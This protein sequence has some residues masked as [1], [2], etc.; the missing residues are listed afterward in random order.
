MDD[1]TAGTEGL[2]RRERQRRQDRQDILDAA[3]ALFAEQG[4]TA[5]SMQAIAERAEFSVGKLYTFFEGKQEIFDQLIRQFLEGMLA[6]IEGAGDPAAEPI[7]NLRRLFEAS[8]AFATENRDLIRVSILERHRDKSERHEDLH[9]AFRRNVT[10]CLESAVAEGILPPLRTELYGRM[11]LG[12]TDEMVM[13]LGARDVPDP[14]AEATDLVMDM[15][16]LPLVRLKE[17]EG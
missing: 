7:E 16:V 4:Y 3:A 15:F 1:R 8:F 13:D 17:L 12:A 14:F 2:T 5:T 6:V 10:R 9:E 11:L